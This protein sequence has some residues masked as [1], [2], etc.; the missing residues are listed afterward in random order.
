MSGV[1][2]LHFDH[3][4]VICGDV[5]K[6]RTFLESTFN[7]SRW[8]EEILDPIQKVIVQFGYDSS[9]ICYELI[10]PAADDSPV[11]QALKSR[12]NIL[13]HIGYITPDLDAAATHLRD[14]GCF[15]VTS[16][17]SAVAFGGARIQFFYSPM[18]FVFELIEGE[19]ARHGI[20]PA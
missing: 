4:G 7:V 2:I 15:P 19:K 3:L 20:R 17:E 14:N 5:E 8:G 13:N 6:S 10:C 18:N 11:Q 12:N 9:G 16:P 1:P